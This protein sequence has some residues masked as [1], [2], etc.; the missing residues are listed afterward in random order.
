MASALVEA[1]TQKIIGNMDGSGKL[2]LKM[3]EKD[4]ETQDLELDRE[5]IKIMQD[6]Q[7]LIDKAKKSKSDAS[8]IHGYQ[9]M[10]AKYQ[11]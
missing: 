9:K 1:Y 3:V 7:I 8:V 2:V 5:K 10:L 4:L 11:S 6:L